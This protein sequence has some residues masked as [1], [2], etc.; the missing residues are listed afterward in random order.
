MKQFCKCG[1]FMTDVTVPNHTHL[2][3]CNNNNLDNDSSENKIMVFH[4]ECCHRLHI[5]QSRYCVYWLDKLFSL[6]KN[7]VPFKQ[8]ETYI[9]DDYGNIYSVAFTNENKQLLLKFHDKI[10]VF[11]LESILENHQLIYHENHSEKILYDKS[12]VNMSLSASQI[13]CPCGWLINLE[14]MDNKSIINLY[15]SVSWISR[16]KYEF[17]ELQNFQY[18]IGLYCEKC[19]RIM[20]PTKKQKY[21]IFSLINEQYIDEDFHFFYYYIK[22]IDE[23]TID[24]EKCGD[25]PTILNKIYISGNKEYIRLE[26]QNKNLFYRIEP[27]DN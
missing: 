5:F 18:L 23:C 10:A 1:Y 13:R 8:D 12:A 4:C 16:V 17:G 14:L 3:L 20:L 24:F 15:D 9:K 7:P 22:P 21:I 2:Q 6:N 26:T 11:R 25:E 19:K 27:V